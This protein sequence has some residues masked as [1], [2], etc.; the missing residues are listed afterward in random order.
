MARREARHD[1]RVPRPSRCHDLQTAITRLGGIATTAEL[2]GASSWAALRACTATGQIVR[3]GH[4]VYTVAA[5]ADPALGGDASSRAWSRW[6]EG[7]SDEEAAA[8]M[9]RRAIARGRG[10]V[11]SHLCAAADHGWPILR[12][13]RWVDIALPV[14]RKPPTF[15]ARTVTRYWER[16]LTT[17]ERA[18]HVT[19]PVRTVIDCARLLPFAEA[20][21]VADSALRSRMVGTRELREAGDV[22]RGS[23]SAQVR[24]VVAGA[25]ARAA[26]PFESALRAVHHGLPGLNLESQ[27]EVGDGLAARVDLADTRLRIVIEADSYAFHG[28]AERFQATQRRQVE[29]AGRDWIVLPYGFAATTRDAAWVR[30]AT[31]AVVYV[32]ERRGYGRA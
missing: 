2:V 9:A 14:H 16:D 30:A 8:L 28:D 22:F 17:E 24:R 32:R 5:F 6:H 25:D 7:P 23:G 31:Q 27:V 3:V 1:G 29:L 11:L 15:A 18:A 26:N 4:G 20:L 13:P 19:A 12:E 21:A 10:G